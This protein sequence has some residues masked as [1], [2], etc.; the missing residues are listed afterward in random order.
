MEKE[1]DSTF[2]DVDLLRYRYSRVPVDAGKETLPGTLS[3][4]IRDQILWTGLAPIF[5]KAISQSTI[6]TRSICMPL[7]AALFIHHQQTPNLS[8][9]ERAVRSYTPGA[10]LRTT[11]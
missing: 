3:S 1:A 11:S 6:S 2:F 9:N 7:D 8:E 10:R 5:H 4:K